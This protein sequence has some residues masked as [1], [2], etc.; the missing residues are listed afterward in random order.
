MSSMLSFNVD[1]LGPS[2]RKPI[3]ITGIACMSAYLIT[4]ELVGKVTT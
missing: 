2:G 1:A 3:K 4:Y